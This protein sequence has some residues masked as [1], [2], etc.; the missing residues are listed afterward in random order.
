MSKLQ[1]YYK[2]LCDTFGVS[3]GAWDMIHL[4]FSPSMFCED[5][6]PTLIA[7]WLIWKDFVQSAKECNVPYYVGIDTFLKE[8]EYAVMSRVKLD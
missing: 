3:C 7:E 4:H 8:Y 6:R 1:E 5:N 2:S